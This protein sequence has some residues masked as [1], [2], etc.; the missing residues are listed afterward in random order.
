MCG[1]RAACSQLY[2]VL[3]YLRIA[4]FV[5]GQICVG[6]M[7]VS[8]LQV[9]CQH[10]LSENNGPAIDGSAGPVPPALLSTYIPYANESPK[11]TIYM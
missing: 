7:R 6:D 9:K 4:K 8:R 1:H 11:P 10:Y 3:F 5:W 2:A